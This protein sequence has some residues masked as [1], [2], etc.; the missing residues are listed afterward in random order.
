VSR[1]FVILMTV[2][3][4]GERRIP[5]LKSIVILVFHLKTAP[6]TALLLYPKWITVSCVC[7]R[8]YACCIKSPCLQ[9]SSPSYVSN[10]K[11]T[12][13]NPRNQ[14]PSPSS[15]FV[16]DKDNGCGIVF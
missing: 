13:K 10:A 2:L 7:A 11:I 16:D 8:Q 9:L 4:F 14:I 15:T 6:P 3:S 1:N 12:P 5:L